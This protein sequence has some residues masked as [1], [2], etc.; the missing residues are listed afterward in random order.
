[1]RVAHCTPPGPDP[2]GVRVTGAPEVGTPTSAGCPALGTSGDPYPSYNVSLEAPGRHLIP[3]FLSISSGRSLLRAAWLCSPAWGFR[4]HPST[5]APR[6]ANLKVT[7]VPPSRVK[8]EDL[9]AWRGGTSAKDAQQAEPERTAVRWF[10]IRKGRS[11]SRGTSDLPNSWSGA[12][13]TALPTSQTNGCDDA[14]PCHVSLSKTTLTVKSRCNHK[15][16]R[17][18]DATTLEGY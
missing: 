7:S 16:R 1:M 14:S 5:P 9:G 18:E 10:M 8:D 6:R 4:R 2:T 11:T 13:D 12:D 3:G 15:A 17:S